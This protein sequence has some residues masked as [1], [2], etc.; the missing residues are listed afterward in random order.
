[1]ESNKFFFTQ[2]AS[3]VLQKTPGQI[4]TARMATLTMNKLDLNGMNFFRPGK[5]PPNL[6]ISFPNSG[7][8][9]L[10]TSSMSYVDDLSI[11][12]IKG[13]KPS[14][15]G[16]MNSNISR[17]DEIMEITSGIWSSLSKDTS[18][19][20]MTNSYTPFKFH[21]ELTFDTVTNPS[22]NLHP[23]LIVRRKTLFLNSWRVLVKLSK[24]GR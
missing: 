19:Q 1:M 4:L 13:N 9:F 15:T 6:L 24:D 8:K 5:V 3:S 12:T 22:S 21:S 11:D 23:K 16:M 18:N 2:P 17:S 20:W 14:S 7:T 10:N